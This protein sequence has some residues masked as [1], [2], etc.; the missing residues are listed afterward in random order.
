MN[1]QRNFI[2]GLF[3]ISLNFYSKKSRLMPAFD[4][5]NYEARITGRNPFLHDYQ[6]QDLEFQFV[7]QL[8]VQL[9]DQLILEL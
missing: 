1:F 8:L 5:C 4:F 2:I 7:S 6:G 3:T 9:L